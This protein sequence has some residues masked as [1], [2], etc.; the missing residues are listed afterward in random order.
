[1][2]YT[3]MTSQ[4]MHIYKLV[5]SHLIILHHLLSVTPVTIT[6]LM[7]VTGVAKKCW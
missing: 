1:M 5:Q 2:F 4:Q 6:T 3:Y 7:M